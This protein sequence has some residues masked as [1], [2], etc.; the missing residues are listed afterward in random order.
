M[1]ISKITTS[2]VS[3]DTLTA[4][5]LA[6][7][8]VDSSELVDGS[9]D[10]SHMSVNS[11]DSD[12][13]VDASIDTAH[14]GDDQVTG[15]KI[16]NN[17][18][19]AGNLTVSG[20]IVPSTPLSHRNMII[21]GGMQLAQR[22]TSFASQTSAN[23]IVDRWTQNIN[24]AQ[25]TWTNGQEA[26]APTGSGFRNSL[27]MNCTAADG[28]PA[29]GDFVRVE[30][31]FEGQDL[32]QIRKGTSSA[33][34]VT[35]S[36]WAKS[37]NT[38]IHIVELEDRDNSR[39]CSQSYTIS[40]ANTWEEFALTFP[41]DTTGVLNDD[42]GES[43][44]VNFWLGAGATWTGGGSLGTTW[45]TT[46]NTR[47]VGQVNVAGAI[48]SSN[49]YWQVTGVQ[50]ELGSNATPFEHRSYGEELARC[51]RYYTYGS[52]ALGRVHGCLYSG[53]TYIGTIFFKQTM[54]AA[55]TI[56]NVSGSY[57][58][59]VGSIGTNSFHFQKQSAATYLDNWTASIE[60]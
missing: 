23:Y 45:H 60:L 32:Q 44:R 26:D 9:V 17:P 1:A 3:A 41:A 22:G 55:P 16:E 35:V 49:N 27:F 4:A 7:N 48:H 38:G 57:S 11:V 54:R 53:S 56:A 6:P 12:Q 30:Q 28:S 58:G 5:D 50:L 40:S 36:F 39:Y 47:A 25:G 15:A 2:G 37:P 18:T 13:Y 29:V 8:S 24:G 31:R 51:Q 52:V 20:D 33:K 59:Q 43:L 34:A 46:A 19:I 14:I 42:N 10:L 21:N